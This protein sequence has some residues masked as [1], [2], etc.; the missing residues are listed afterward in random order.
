MSKTTYTNY[1][2]DSNFVVISALKVIYLIG[3]AIGDKEESEVKDF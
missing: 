3:R 1:L 2:T